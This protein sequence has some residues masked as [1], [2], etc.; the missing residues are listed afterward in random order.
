M[1][2]NVDEATLEGTG[3]EVE[4]EEK[5]RLD[6]T[7]EVTEAGP[8]KKHVKVT[9]PRS[10]I[11]KFFNK[12]FSDLVKNAAVPGFRPGKTPRKLIERRFK[13]DVAS[14][15]KASVLMQS[16]EQIGEEQKIEP[17]SDPEIDIQ[18]LDI[19]EDG[20]FVYEFDVEVRPEFDTPDYKG[21]KVEKPVKE[22]SDADV[23][24]GVEGFLRRNGEFESKDGAAEK[25]DYLI[26]DVKF[27]DGDSPLNQ[28]EN[29]RVRIDD[30]LL[31]RDG[32]VDGFAEAV[33]GV[34]V[35]ETR[36]VSAVLADSAVREDLR[37]KPVKAVFDVKEVQRLVVPELNEA[38]LAQIGVGDVG[39]LRDIIKINL[40]RRLESEQ[41]QACREQVM[42]KLLTEATW[43]L[44]A[45]L[46]RKQAVRTL[47][48]EVLQLQEAGLG[49][50]EIQTRLNQ[51]RQQS[52]QATAVSL[53]Q[54]FL[55]QKI[56]EV[57][58]IKVED[59]DLDQEIFELAMRT[60]ENPRR[61]RAR[62]EK[63]QLW[64]T[65]ALHILERKTVERIISFADVSEVPY[66]KK[67]EIL[68][69][70]VDESVIAEVPESTEVPP[71][72]DA[73]AAE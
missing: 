39:E 61:V 21:I 55:L 24:E 20:D 3:T 14:Q 2:E 40:E 16:L 5:E 57:E 17:L 66:E 52:V 41:Q 6:L 64:D 45:D 18:A 38:F 50:E 30:E 56:A 67:S 68:G 49:E 72:E 60:G 7:A 63:E 33:S 25:G 10:E 4:T 29:L 51:L 65:L 1:S 62:V 53:K 44:P 19:P 70:A 46:L 59:G 15:V 43:E 69:A 35:G 8:C 23:D 54:Q 36:E 9:I 26:A 42:K 58:E 31:F 28:A 27:V 13:K 11:D 22:I 34:K 12:E 48:R 71:A 73:P 37:G 47:R 32:R